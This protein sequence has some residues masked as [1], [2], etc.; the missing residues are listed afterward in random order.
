MLIEEIM[1]ILVVILIIGGIIYLINKQVY[2]FNIFKRAVILQDINLEKSFNKIDTDY[3]K[4]KEDT[5]DIN[6]AN[7]HQSMND[8]NLINNI[9]NIN[10][11]NGESDELSNFYPLSNNINTSISNT[12]L[13]DSPE[14]IK[15]YSNSKNTF[16]EDN[17]KQYSP[18]NTDLG[19]SGYGNYGN[20]VLLKKLDA[21]L[22][23]LEEQHDEKTNYVTE[24]L[25][26]YVFLGVFVIF[27]L[28][29]FV[30]VGKYVR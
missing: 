21:I 16:I 9:N 3:N 14:T 29:S 18:L 30:R 17:Y 15:G 19:N 5:N 11:E 12:K 28:D 25:I 8:V 24:E 4:I 22:H 20:D 23:I 6:N 1:I 26:L 13:D 2:D 7:T 27:V 10:A